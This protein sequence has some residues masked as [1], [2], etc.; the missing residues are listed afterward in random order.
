[1]V[2]RWE[3]STASAIHG[4][5][6]QRHAWVQ[7]WTQ[8][9]NPATCSQADNG[10]LHSS[11]VVARVDGRKPVG[12]SQTA[13]MMEV[14]S[15]HVGMRGARSS[16]GAASPPVTVAGIDA[17]VTSAS[18]RRQRS[19]RRGV[20]EDHVLQVSIFLRHGRNM[21]RQFATHL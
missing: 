6:P 10:I 15:E 20:S 4:A 3:W 14:V 12:T 19:D 13:S 17:V 21:S 1:M 8:V 7:R 5:W 11:R 9:P 18:R 2:T 16:G